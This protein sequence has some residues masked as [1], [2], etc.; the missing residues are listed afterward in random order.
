MS[1]NSNDE[2][3]FGS[4]ADFE[5]SLSPEEKRRFR[6]SQRILISNQPL[7]QIYE[8][9]KTDTENNKGSLWLGGK[10][11]AQDIA[12][13]RRRGITHILT[14]NG[15]R[16]FLYG[17]PV[18][19]KVIDWDDSERETLEPEL[20]A[21]V[22]WLI[23]AL[24]NGGSVLI[25]CTAG[26][27]RSASVVVAILIKCWG[28]TY[29]QA[30]GHVRRIRPWATPNSG[31]EK[32]LREFEQ[33]RKSVDHR[34][35]TT[36]TRRKCDAAATECELCQ[37][38]KT[39]EWYFEHKDFVIIECDQCDQPMAVWRHHMMEIT[40]DQKVEMETF[41]RRIADQ[42]IGAG[43]YYVDKTQRSIATH[44]HWHARIGQNPWKKWA[45]LVPSQKGK[46]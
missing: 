28:L 38:E 39:T 17:V 24:A 10:W 27:S 41:L 2:Q 44:L 35:A 29:D 20:T 42:K 8:F 23:D 7:S 1:D 16:P 3:S 40:E 31:F 30:L 22:E 15:R 11:A 34:L 21:G 6:D 32:Q 13:H 46:L 45:K 36:T 19:L 12:S 37:M 9:Q 4:L 18:E 43:K 14:T 5:G 33:E 25:H 26:R